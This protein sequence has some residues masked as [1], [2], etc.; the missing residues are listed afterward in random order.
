MTIPSPR[1]H[2]YWKEWEFASL[3]T[4]FPATPARLALGPLCVV[5]ADEEQEDAQLLGLSSLIFALHSPGSCQPCRLARPSH[6][7][8][9][10]SLPPECHPRV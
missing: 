1:A 2:L 10:C 9:L 7:S 4:A 8:S 3:K 6:F 5:F